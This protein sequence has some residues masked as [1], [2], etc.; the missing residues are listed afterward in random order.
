MIIS[1]LTNPHPQRE[2]AVLGETPMSNFRKKAPS[3]NGGVRVTAEC[4]R[5]MGLEQTVN[6]RIH[7]H[8]INKPPA[9]WSFYYT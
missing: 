5:G 4:G 8:K 9:Q 3:F 2:S 7:K 6:C 1:I